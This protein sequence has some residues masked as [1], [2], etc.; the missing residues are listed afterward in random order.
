M[1]AWSALFIDTCI[2]HQQAFDFKSAHP[3]SLVAAAKGSAIKL[4]LPHPVRLEIERHLDE[5]AASAVSALKTARRD[6]P[7]L[8]ELSGYP[9]SRAASTG[10]G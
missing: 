2:F 9:R 1:P 10:S 7:L 8:R 3:D 4:P 6:H 5:L